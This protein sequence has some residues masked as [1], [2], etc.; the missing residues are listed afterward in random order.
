MIAGVSTALVTQR[1]FASSV[2]GGGQT[3][4]SSTSS[5]ASLQQSQARPAASAATRPSQA[6]TGNSGDNDSGRPNQFRIDPNS[7]DK[8]IEE[9]NP[10]TG[11]IVAQY[12][13]SEFPALAKGLGLLGSVIN[14]TA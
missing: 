3:D 5:T 11:E 6:P 12:S 1:T 7:G 4:R 13:V 2:S 8:L 10:A 9:I 14:S